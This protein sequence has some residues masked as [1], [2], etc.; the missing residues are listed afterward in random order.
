MPIKT[1]IFIATSLDGFIARK[2]GSLDWL[3]RINKTVPAGVDGGFA[4][5]LASV[6]ALVMGRNTF[7]QVLSFN[8]WPYGQKPVIVLANKPLEIPTD[9]KTTVSISHESPSA[10]LLRLEHMGIK[11][12]YVDGGL[13]IQSFIKEGLINEMTI[14]LAP[15]ALGEGKPLFGALATD[16][17]LEHISTKSFHGFVQIKYRINQTHFNITPELA[18]KL[19]TAQF[20]EL[21]HLP[22]RSV[23][24]QGH[25]NRTYRVGEHLLIRMPTDESYAL[26]VPKEQKLLPKTIEIQNIR[27]L[28]KYIY[29]IFK[30][31]LEQK[32]QKGG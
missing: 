1:S 22:I 7:E 14:T 19:I 13:T 6:N 4:D 30:R 8:H 27:K 9:L 16:I 32:Q 5:F 28:F 10:L 29:K 26:K 21:A 23:E 18:H 2:D 17:G 12:V 24:K 25:D 3:D 15:V 20:P 11:H 31:Y